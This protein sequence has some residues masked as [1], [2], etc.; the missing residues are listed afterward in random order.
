[1]E[2]INTVIEQNVQKRPELVK[3][4]G[5][6]RVRTRPSVFSNFTFSPEEFDPELKSIDSKEGSGEKWLTV[7][8]SGVAKPT[9]NVFDT[10]S[11]PT[12]TD[13]HTS[14][15]RSDPVLVQEDERC[16]SS[17]TIL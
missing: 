3:S 9:Q 5:P 6:V 4:R 10:F 8:N 1:M 14:L 17:C 15:L 16:C 7:D 11:A 13:E 12:Q 2:G